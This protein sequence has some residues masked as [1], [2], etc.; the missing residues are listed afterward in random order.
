MRKGSKIKITEETE[1]VIKVKIGDEGTEKE[2]HKD[3]LESK[4]E[5]F[6]VDKKEFFEKKHE[7]ERLC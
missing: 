1:E 2:A 5:G 6:G 4:E 3:G 7:K